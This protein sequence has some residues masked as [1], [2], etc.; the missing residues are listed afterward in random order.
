MVNNFKGLGE[1]PK[2]VTDNLYPGEDVIYCIKKK[3]ALELKP[4]YLVISDRRVIFY[5]QKIAGRYNF[6][7]IPYSKLERVY[8]NQGVI[9]SKFT[10]RGED[11]LKIS[12]SWLD[13]TECK[14]AII[15]IRDAIN[16]IAIEPVSIQK[17]KTLIGEK[18]VLKKPKEIIT[19]TMPL[20]PVIGRTPPEPDTDDPVYKLRKLK[21][22]NDM[23]LL[24]KD[25]YDD[26]RMQI[27]S[28]F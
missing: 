16:S 17:K 27:I 21:E 25:E 26:K 12:L 19:R 18:W 2:D 4:R 24:S 7:D 13:K 15:T 1:I 3:I 10:L 23:G 9:A 11:K 5:D 6:Y 20:A 28:E 14:D 8:F 22:M